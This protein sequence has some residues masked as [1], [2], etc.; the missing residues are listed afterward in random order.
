MTFI[1][2]KQ[3]VFIPLQKLTGEWCFVFWKRITLC[4]ETTQKHKKS[5]GE[6]GACSNW[7]HC[8][9][10][11][12]FNLSEQPYMRF[13]VAGLRARVVESQY[14]YPFQVIVALDSTA[15]ILPQARI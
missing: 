6:K 14:Y 11:K 3:T 7:F 5:L 10:S 13:V 15:D 9:G 2:R 4:S 12:K 1:P 8:I